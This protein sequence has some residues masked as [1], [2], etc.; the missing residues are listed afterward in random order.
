MTGGTRRPFQVT[1]D[2]TVLD[3]ALACHDCILTRSRA[4]H[5]IAALVDE[6]LDHIRDTGHHVTITE[7]SQVTYGPPETTP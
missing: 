3:P 1:R 7:I 2:F 6:A 5:Q 4:V